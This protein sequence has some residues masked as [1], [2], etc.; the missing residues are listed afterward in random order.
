M[1]PAKPLKVSSTNRV[2]GLIIAFKSDTEKN[3]AIDKITYSP[4]Q[5]VQIVVK[6]DN[7]RCACDVKSYKFKLLRRIEVN[8]G[9]TEQ[10]KLL[11][12]ID[13]IDDK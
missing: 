4:G 5:Q 7:S 6:T 13:L 1:T 8:I 3:F 2:G 11:K 10:P 9:T 12:K